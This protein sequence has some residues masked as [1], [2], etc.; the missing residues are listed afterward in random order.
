[1]SANSLTE[2]SEVK[3][4]TPPLPSSASRCCALSGSSP[5]ASASIDAACSASAAR[6]ASPCSA[7]PLRK[8]R[9][10]PPAPEQ[11]LGREPRLLARLRLG[12]EI[13]RERIDPSIERQ[14][15]ALQH[16]PSHRSR[17]ARLDASALDHQEVSVLAELELDPLDPP[18]LREETNR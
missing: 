15:L 4:L 11:L 16:D 7:L 6:L 18:L 9:I 13:T 10:R 17:S 1:M 14:R 2:R 8:R 3:R 5:R 12:R